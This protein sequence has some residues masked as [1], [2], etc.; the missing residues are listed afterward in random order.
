MN[1]H[2]RNN[3]EFLLSL[4]TDA[5]WRDWFEF[6]DEEDHIYAMELIKTAQ[7]ELVVKTLE[8]QEKYAVTEDVSQAQQILNRFRLNT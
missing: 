8:L 6:T 5:E 2:D 3:L 7:S 1:K 4:K